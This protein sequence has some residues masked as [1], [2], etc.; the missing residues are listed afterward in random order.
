MS[1]KSSRR[2]RL[3][4][5]S[6]K[7]IMCRAFAAARSPRTSNAFT[8]MMSPNGVITSWP[9]SG[10]S[11]ECHRV[12]ALSPTTK[13]APLRVKSSLKRLDTAACRCGSGYLFKQLF[14]CFF[15]SFFFF[16]FNIHILTLYFALN[17]YFRFRLMI[18]QVFNENNLLHWINL[19]SFKNSEVHSQLD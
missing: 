13:H 17:K 9:Q 5:R 3:D 14:F 10:S 19:L 11:V 2:R 16:F 6:Q 15:A 1:Q 8:P 7:P 12:P 4:R 18:L